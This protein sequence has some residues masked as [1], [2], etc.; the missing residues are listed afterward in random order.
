M[1]NKSSYEPTQLYIRHYPHG[2]FPV[3]PQLWSPVN[4]IR[5]TAITSLLR[6]ETNE[7]LVELYSTLLSYRPPLLDRSTERSEVFDGSAHA[8]KTI[9]SLVIHS[10]GG[11]I[12]GL[13]VIYTDGTNSGEHGNCGAKIPVFVLNQGK[14]IKHTP[15]RAII[16][17]N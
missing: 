7:K 11:G 8:L 2:W 12:L 10:E 14:S 15:C 9:S 3:P 6:P 1:V 17:T 16:T 5:V 13:S 4:I